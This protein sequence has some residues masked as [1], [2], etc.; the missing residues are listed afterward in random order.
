[1]AFA[2]WVVNDLPR[3]VPRNIGRK[4]EASLAASS[5]QTPSY[6]QREAERIANEVRKVLRMAG[7]DLRERHR[8][9]LE[10]FAEQVREAET[11]RGTAKAAMEFLTKFVADVDRERGRVEAV[12]VDI[13]RP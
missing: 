5:S 13:S 6:S 8:K 10:D 9:D 3:A 4:L 11:K 7:Y 2:A 12:E 1:V